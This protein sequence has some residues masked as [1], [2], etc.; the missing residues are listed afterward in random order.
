[1]APVEFIP[2]ILFVLSSG[3][4]FNQ[5]FRENIV[6]VTIA[7]LIGLVSSYYLIVQITNDVV[8]RQLQ[9]AQTQGNGALPTGPSTNQTKA[10]P[11]SDNPPKS[12]CVVF[13]GKTVCE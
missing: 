3:L 5:Q 6:L 9:E 11:V 12:V 13:N 10:D 1:M 4:L 8:H 7:G 2:A